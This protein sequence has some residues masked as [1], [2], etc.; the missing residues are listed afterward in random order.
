[1]DKSTISKAASRL[2][3][4]AS[5]EIF[6]GLADATRQKLLQLLLAEELNVTELVGILAQPQSTISRHLKVLRATGLVQD[7]RNGATSLYSAVRARPGQDELHPVLLDWL[8]RR[9]LPKRLQDRLR[10]VL[11]RR[12]NRAVGFFERLGERWDEL[13]EEAFGEAFAT[14]AFLAL[15]PRDWTVVDIG[16][17]TGYL[18]PVLAEHFR[19]VIAVEPAEAMLECARQR[20]AAQGSSKVLFHHGDLGRLPIGDGTCDL[21]IACLVLHHVAEPAEALG[22]MYRVLRSGGRILIVEQEAHESEAFYEMMQDCWW[23]FDPAD[24]ARRIS[25]AG[26][27]NVRHHSLTAGRGRRGAMESPGLFVVT[28]E[29][30]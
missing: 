5:E 12:Q 29:G 6:R 25:A 17:G 8:R 28:A 19:E 1:M 15:L 30:P 16:T 4:P 18:L 27:R 21:A 2:R 9:P 24:L 23:G 10:R 22:E 11:R 13:R 14:E 3:V 20:A 7:R 26:F